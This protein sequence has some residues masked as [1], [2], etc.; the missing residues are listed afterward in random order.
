MIRNLPSRR[1]GT[2][3]RLLSALRP[4]RRHGADPA[5]LL[6]RLPPV[7]H[8]PAADEDELFQQAPL[9][10]VLLLMVRIDQ[11]TEYRLCRDLAEHA[12]GSVPDPDTAP[13]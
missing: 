11:E 8:R 7:E 2:P 5:G 6:D 4:A 13:D 3:S 9:G 10:Q 1:P 12:L